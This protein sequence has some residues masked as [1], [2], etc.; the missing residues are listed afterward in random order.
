MTGMCA[1]AVIKSGMEQQTTSRWLDSAIQRLRVQLDPD[2][3]LLFGSRARGTQTR[4]SDLDLLI[5][6]RTQEPVLERIGRV[7]RLLSDSPWP[8]EVLVY[9]PDELASKLHSPF[10]RRVLREARVLYERRAA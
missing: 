9:T 5:V 7:L 2:L 3:I 4:K 10:L 1:L 8:V 6:M